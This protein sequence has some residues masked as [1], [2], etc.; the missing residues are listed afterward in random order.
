M[1]LDS[2]DIELLV[3][4]AHDV[5][6]YGAGGDL[7]AVG[8]ARFFDYEAVVAGKGSLRADCA[9]HAPAVETHFLGDAVLD[10]LGADDLA[11]EGAADRLMAEAD[12]EHRNFAGEMPD[13]FDAD[14]GVLGT[15]GSGRNDQSARGELFKIGD[16]DAVVPDDADFLA[17]KA[18]EVLVHVIGE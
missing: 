12:A 15:A 3:P 5:A 16:R 17:G 7:E 10:E 8:K 11:A 9:E 13:R 2:F 6:V 18:G 14:A 1:E 4:D